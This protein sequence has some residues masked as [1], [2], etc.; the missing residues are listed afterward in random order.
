MKDG[1]KI[2]I[3]QN[4]ALLYYAYIATK[5]DSYTKGIEAELRHQKYSF[6]GQRKVAHDWTDLERRYKDS[7]EH[8]RS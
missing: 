8:E 5:L 6:L 7:I 1:N 3:L 4:T 2:K